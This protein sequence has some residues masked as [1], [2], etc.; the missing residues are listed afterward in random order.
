[1]TQRK[2]LVIGIGNSLMADDGAG[3][4]TVSLLA[5]RLP[6]D[7]L[8]VLAT[9]GPGLLSFI[10]DRSKV[11]VVDA[12][13]FGGAPGEV[14]RV[15]AQDMPRGIAAAPLSLHDRG[16]AQVWDEALW[17]DMAPQELV[18]YCIQAHF[19]GPRQALSPGVEE[20]CRAAADLIARELS[21]A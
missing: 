8:R 1:M 6:A 10:H 12:A 9:P 15:A 13:K 5:G 2:P 21:H 7:Q 18:F 16:A 4:F 14:R 17:L 20:G 3:P 19:I 11:I